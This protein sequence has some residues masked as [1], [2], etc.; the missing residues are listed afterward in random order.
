MKLIGFIF[1]VSLSYISGKCD[2]ACS[3][4]GSCTLRGVCECYDNWGL[5]LSHDSGDCSQRICPYEFAWVDTPDKSG[6]HHKYSEC[7]AKGI[8]N[9]DSGECECFPGY[10]GKGC[11]RTTCPNDCSGHGTCAFIEDLPYKIVPDDYKHGT[12]GKLDPY[13]FTYYQWDQSKTR[14]CICD[15]MYGDV[16]CSKRI[17]PYG[18]DVMDI[19]DTMSTAAKYQIQKITLVAQNDAYFTSKRGVIQGQ[20]FSLTFKSRLNET[21]TTIPLVIKASHNT[22]FHGFLQNVEDALESLPNQVIDDVKVEGSIGTTGELGTDTL[23]GGLYVNLNI[24]FVGDNVQGPQHLLT[25]NAI[26][27]GDGCTPKQDGLELQAGSQNVTEVT[28]SDF[29]SYECG[30]RGKC[31]YTSGNCVCFAGYAGLACNT[32]TAL[33]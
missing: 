8:C 27:C 4:H 29:N 10:E 30:R 3:G 24:T 1:I 21:F 13:T 23:S 20:T 6:Y 31:D 26:N 22:G 17:C 9:R 33:V 25:I 32:I 5:G 19:R 16:D 15:P 14:G 12:F 7:S 28:L 11:Q 18:T 2:N